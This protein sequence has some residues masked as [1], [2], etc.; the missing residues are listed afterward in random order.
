MKT[1]S[2]VAGAVIGAVAAVAISKKFFGGKCPVCG[3]SGSGEG[4]AVESLRSSVESLRSE[5]SKRI[6]SEQTFAA[7]CEELKD[8]VAKQS[9]EIENL[10]N[11]CDVQ[12]SCNKKL[13]QELAQVKASK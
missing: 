6:E 3:E 9:V 13:E 12:N 7:Q 8:Q 10:K 5:L 1:E 4:D 11:V 2:F